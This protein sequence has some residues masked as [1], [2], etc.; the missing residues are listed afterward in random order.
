MLLADP[1]V[2]PEDRLPDAAI[3]RAIESALEVAREGRHRAIVRLLKAAQ[4]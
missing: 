4:W 2:I 1:R 3:E